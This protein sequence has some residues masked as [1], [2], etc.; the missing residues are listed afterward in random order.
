MLVKLGKIAKHETKEH[1][2]RCIRKSKGLLESFKD[3]IKSVTHGKT[4]DEKYERN[5][6]IIKIIIRATLLCAEQGVALRGYIKQDS[7]NDVGKNS[8]TEKTMQRG[9]FL[10]IINVFA[11]LDAVLMEHIEKGVKNAKMVSWQI[12]NDITECLSEFVRPKLK[13]EIPDYY[14]IISDEVTDRFSNKDILV[15]CLLYV[16]FC[17]NEKT[18]YLQ[19]IF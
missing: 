10:V 4:S 18:L 11:A 2:K 13:D 9:N 8:H 19:N 14:A 12:Q 16:K 15:L 7:S 5:I 3:P 17:V 6:H 1:H